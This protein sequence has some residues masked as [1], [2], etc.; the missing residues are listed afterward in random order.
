[1]SLKRQGE[2]EGSPRC[3]DRRENHERRV[4]VVIGSS[5]K[6]ALVTQDPVLSG[7]HVWSLL[8]SGAV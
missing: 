7:R 2:R 4:H 6:S 8:E 5:A 3:L 1:M